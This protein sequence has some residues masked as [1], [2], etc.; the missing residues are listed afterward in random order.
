MLVWLSQLPL[1]RQ[2]RSRNR[3]SIIRL[4]RPLPHLFHSQ[5]SYNQFRLLHQPRLLRLSL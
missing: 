4:R 2:L 5:S 3:W 1:C